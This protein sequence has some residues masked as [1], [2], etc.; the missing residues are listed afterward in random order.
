[1]AKGGDK[2]N[3]HV[4][5]LSQWSIAVGQPDGSGHPIEAAASDFALLEVE[6]ERFSSYVI[7]IKCDAGWGEAAR[8]EIGRGQ[9]RRAG[10]RSA[11]KLG[12]SD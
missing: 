4:G 1:M 6:Q 8:R 11:R 2:K 9:A 10:Q 5:Y 3:A 12:S 7:A